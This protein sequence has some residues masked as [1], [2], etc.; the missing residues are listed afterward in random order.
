MVGGAYHKVH[1]TTVPV[2]QEEETQDSSVRDLVVERLTVK[3]QERRKY[4][5]VITTTGKKT[6][7]FHEM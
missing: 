6:Q 1:L 5:D 2:R 4:F 3:L 7:R